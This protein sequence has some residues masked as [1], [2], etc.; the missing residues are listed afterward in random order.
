MS[1]T[2]VAPPVYGL[3]DLGEVNSMLHGHREFLSK[4]SGRTGSHG[5]TEREGPTRWNTYSSDKSSTRSL[6]S[7]RL[8]DSPIA[9]NDGADDGSAIADGRP[10]ARAWKTDHRVSMGPEKAWSIG[11]G[12]AAN[13]EDGQV[14]K[15]ISEV[16]A[17]VEHNNRS[18]KASHSLRFFKAGLPEEKGKRKDQR[19]ASMREKSPVR[20]E[21]LADIQEQPVVRDAKEAHVT[22]DDSSAS[23]RQDRAYPTPDNTPRATTGQDTAEDYFVPKQ[24]GHMRVTEAEPAVS[25]PRESV[26]EEHEVSSADANSQ[27]KPRRVSDLSVGAG[28]STED[29]EESG[30]EKISSAVFVPHQAPEEEQQRVPLPGIPQRIVPSRRHSRND[31]FHPWLVKADE[32]EEDDKKASP[33]FESKAVPQAAEYPSVTPEV[34]SRQVDEFSPVDFREAAVPSSRLSRPVS[35]YHGD[36]VHDHQLTPKQPLEAIELIPYKHQVGG[37]TTLWRFSRRAVCKQ[38][39]NRENEFYEKIERYHRDL[40][41]F[42]PR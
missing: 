8:T 35:E 7:P 9:L 31:D 4:K 23:D 1:T 41:A 34:A 29:G 33:D 20:G 38:L 40:L 32:P 6:A 24:G 14:E 18:R 5:P 11:S 3:L 12:D 27:P 16:L 21:R 15:S 28:E 25:E 30:E 13:C 10:H 26:C 37:H 2:V 19:S 22:G 39:N 17:G 42:L 36:A